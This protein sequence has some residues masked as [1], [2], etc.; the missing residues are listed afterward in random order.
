MNTIWQLNRKRRI[1]V[2]TRVTA[3]ARATRRR[4]NR[5]RRR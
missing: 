3:P 1:I 4:K 2:G 5:R